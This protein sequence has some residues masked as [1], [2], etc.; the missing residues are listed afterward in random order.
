M[1]AKTNS[2]MHD[3]E[4]HAKALDADMEYYYTKRLLPLALQ[5]FRKRYV[6]LYDFAT[7][8]RPLVLPDSAARE[9]KKKE[10]KKENDYEARLRTLEDRFDEFVK[11]INRIGPGWAALRGVAVLTDDVRKERGDYDEFFHVVTRRERTG[12]DGWEIRRSRMADLS[13]RISAMERDLSNYETVLEVVTSVLQKNG[14]INIAVARRLK[15]RRRGKKHYPS[16]LNGAKIVSRAWVD[17]E[18]K[19]RLL[20]NAREAVRELGIP[21]GR[22]GQLQV[23]ENTEKVHNVIV[24]TLC[25]CYPYDLLGNA[26]WWYKQDAYKTRIVSEPRRTLEDMFEFKVPADMEIRVHDSTSDVRYMVLPRRPLNSEG[27]SEE[28]L[29][30]LVTKDSLI[31]VGDVL[32]ARRV[33]TVS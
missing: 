23:V 8:F 9:R 28:E 25:S 10:K 27:M 29:G 11:G 19:R 16:L 1:A 22:L 31:G 30:K 32:S 20:A 33:T 12:S 6:D 7:T 15:G 13:S 3:F 21:P 18:F 5:L 26:P 2:H 24:C 17:P 4:A 14:H